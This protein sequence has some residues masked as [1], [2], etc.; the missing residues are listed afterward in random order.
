MNALTKG[1]DLAKEIQENGTVLLENKNNCLPLKKKENQ[2]K[3]KVNIFGWGGSDHG[4][5]YQGG[6]SSEGGY[7]ADRIS[8]YDAFRNNG[9][10]INEEL[11]TA[12]NNLSYRR[13]GGPDQNQHSVYYRAYDP[14][15]NFFTDSLMNNAVNFSEYAIVV[16]S[17]R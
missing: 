14:A 4:F 3:I 17:R 10:E 12:Y 7:S 16:L 9:F 1:K 8:L 6:G 15:E 13:E 11:A 2:E 5:L